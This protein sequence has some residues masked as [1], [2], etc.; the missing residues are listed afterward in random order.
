MFS[1]TQFTNSLLGDLALDRDM[2]VT[3]AADDLEQAY[4]SPPPDQFVA[5][6]WQVLREKWLGRSPSC[7]TSVVASLRNKGLGDTSIKVSTKTSEMNYLRTCRATN[8]LRAIVLAEFVLAGQ[9]SDGASE[10]RDEELAVPAADKAD[11][12]AVAD[13]GLTAV[14]KLF[15]QMMIDAE[16]AVRRPRG[17]TWWGY[18]LAQHVEA[19][20]PYEIADGVIGAVVRIWTEV[21]HD[22]DESHEPLLG[23]LSA[24]NGMES[25]SA[26]VF[27]PE[28]R[29]VDE[30]LTCAVFDDTVD[31]WVPVLAT[32]AIFQNTAAHS[33][34]RAL[35]EVVEGVPAE[36]SHPTSGQRE[37]M[38]EL[39]DGAADWVAASGQ[40]ESAFIGE[41][42]AGIPEF[43]ARFGMFSTG[44]ESGFTAEI[45]F[46]STDNGQ[47]ALVQVFTD[48][49]HPELGSGALWV[50][51][52][53]IR[54]ESDHGLRLAGQ[55]NL[56]EASGEAPSKLLGAWTSRDD[57]VVYVSFV[58]SM[59][60]RD[61]LIEN[62]LIDAAV[63]SGW[64]SSLVAQQA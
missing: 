24:V 44:D 4:G 56:I 42:L 49:P 38:D 6:T 15:E 41:R 43:A 58:P 35:A 60:A 7:R 26:V 61:G 23:M 22:V 63:R 16:W 33:R 2:R 37:E 48:Q 12:D 8:S 62:L 17:F 50:A 32:A 45:G 1:W 18:R 59:L 27:D 20:E 13:A 34:A 3:Y 54:F 11:A 25:M 39:L 55:L 9:E 52:F 31:T 10:G 29:A 46:G 5:D 47:T 21:V 53:P 57:E 28:R 36:S 14:G 64:F 19:G 51:R 30:C 40:K